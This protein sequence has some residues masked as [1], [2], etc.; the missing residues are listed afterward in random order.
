MPDTHTVRVGWDWFSDPGYWASR[1]VLQRLL[2]A[3]YLI[4]FVV[5]LNQF[6]ALIGEH[7]LLPVPRFLRSASW[8]HAPSIFQ[9]HYSDR[10]FAAVAW[11]G[12]VVS[13]ALLLGA[14]DSAPVWLYMT[15]WALLWVLYLSIVNVGQIWYS[16]GWESL[17][18]EAGFLAIFLGPSDMAPPVLTLWLMR[19]LLFRVEFG[20]GIIKIRGDA[21]WRDLTCLDYHHETQPA[22]GPL[23]WY[24]HHLPPRMHKCEVLG[25]H[26]A[27]LVVPFALFAPQPAATIAAGVVIVTQGWLVISGNFA[28]LN[29]VTIVLAL[30]AVDGSLLAPLL[31]ASRPELSAAPAWFDVGVLGLTVFVAVLSYWPARNMIGRKQIM[32]FS[33]NRLHLVNTYGAFGNV[34]KARHEVVLEGTDDPEIT[35]D[36]VWREY[37]FKV[38]PGD[39]YRRPRQVAPYHLRLDWLMWFASLSSQYS[40]RWLP[41]LAEK[42]LS[43]DRTTLKLLRT[44]PFDGKP[45]TFLRAHLFQYRF[46]TR[47]ERAETGAWWMREPVGMALRTCHLAEDGTAVPAGDQ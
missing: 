18:L 29:A 26:F 15:A 24:F 32:N 30:A 8:R 36:T 6:R 34:T 12:V 25:N 39:P 2:A 35:G 44:D 13:A 5:A 16:F 40:Q 22:P 1:L 43:A 31:P 7:G 47:Q 14:G 4:A 9:W 3:L 33:F 37:E 38:K 46:T 10:L 23:S 11:I 28:W 19:W 20:A 27:Q 17:L 21:C 45:P 42:L 41:R